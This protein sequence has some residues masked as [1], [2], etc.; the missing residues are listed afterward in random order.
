MAM[1]E[2]KDDALKDVYAAK[3]VPAAG[4]VILQY[5]N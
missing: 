1:M 5:T 3:H 4:G 2:L